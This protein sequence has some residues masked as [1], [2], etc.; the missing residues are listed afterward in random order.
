MIDKNTKSI[1]DDIR[2]NVLGR[3]NIVE[4]AAA[5][6]ILRV[7]KR[8]GK[9]IMASVLKQDG[10]TSGTRVTSLLIALSGLGTMASSVAPAFSDGGINLGNIDISSLQF[11]FTTMMG[12]LTAFFMRRALPSKKREV[13]KDE[14]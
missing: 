5:W 8:E 2:A 12:G 11:G 3:L 6:V 14:S 1:G 13:A 4:K 10:R 7:I 9:N